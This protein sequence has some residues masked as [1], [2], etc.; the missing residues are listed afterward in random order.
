MNVD[1]FLDTNILVYAAAGHGK[2]E[3]KRLRALELLEQENFGISAQVL[4]EFYVTTVYKIA[5]PLTAAK[6][7]DWIDTLATLP[8]VGLDSGLV[9]IAILKSAQFRISYWDA[10]I[11]A[12]AEAMGAGK[13]F[14]EDLNHGQ[15]YGR[16][17]VVNPFLPH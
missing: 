4:Q 7:M 12:A 5:R 2:E 1:S 17:Q 10:A 13:V 15:V 11:L 8:C 3:K 9:K 14:S 6:A 16:V